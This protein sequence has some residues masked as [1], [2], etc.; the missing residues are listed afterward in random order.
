[1]ERGVEAM[2]NVEGVGE[3]KAKGRGKVVL[4]VG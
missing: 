1:L 3:K 4:T 2:G